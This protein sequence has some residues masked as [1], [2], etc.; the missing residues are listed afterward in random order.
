[1]A[2]KRYTADRDNTITNAYKANLTTRGVSGNMGQSDILEVFHIYGQASSDS[3]ENCRILVRFPTDTIA[4]DRTAGT[5]PASGSVSFYLRMFN[6]AHS[7][8]TPAN[9]ILTASALT[10]DWQEGVGLDMENYSDIDE[11]NW[12]YRT[13]TKIAQVAT[14]SFLSNTKGDYGGKYISLYDTSDNR[15]NFWFNDG[16]DSAPTIDGTEIEVDISAGGLTTAAHYADTF[17]TVVDDQS[18]FTATVDSADAGVQNDTAGAVTAPT[19]NVEVISLTTTTAGSDYTAWTT[20]GGDYD[21]TLSSSFQQTFTTGFEDLEIDIS[22]LMEQWLSSSDNLPT[23]TDMGLKSNYG[24]GVFLT[25]SEEGATV[26]YYTKMFFARGSQFFFKRPTIEARWDNSKSDDRGNFYLSSSLVPASDNLMNL[27]LYNVVKGQL[28]NIPVVDTGNIF[29]S[30]Y[31]GTTAGIT[32]SAAPTGDKL[33]LPEG[34]G[35]AANRDVNITASF[36]ET[37][38]YSASFAYVSSSITTIYDVWHT[39]SAV[40]EMVHYHT[41]S[42]ITVKTFNASGY[43]P[44]Q[45]YVSNITNLRDSYST[46]ETAR[47]RLYTRKKNWRPNI[48]VK[49]SVDTPNDIVEN[50]YY[51]ITRISDS[52]NIVA[53]GTGSQ[54]QTKLSYD[55]SGSYFDFDMSMLQ[56]DEIYALNF[57]YKVNGNYVEQTPQF[58]FRVE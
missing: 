4:T 55:N 35:V 41:G 39:S 12:L 37:G 10:A 1:M 29:V 22:P 40:A 9:F 38:I 31:S 3:S 21:Y 19:G 33:F 53:Y 45:T 57:V 49:A 26:S 18:E 43:N 47:F 7:Q 54:N 56:A 8:P 50:V 15:Y 58:R 16:D 14:A 23:N 17:K 42:A 36:V 5:I 13:D 28:T 44:N 27:Y 24:L 11:S 32:S 6:A 2:I 25:S 46:Q 34:G 30:I 51:K 48:Y 52:Y 20:E